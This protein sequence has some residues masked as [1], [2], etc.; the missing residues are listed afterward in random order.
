[1][2]VEHL[3]EFL[4]VLN[5]HTSKQLKS[6]Q[7]LP[8]HRNGVLEK[9]DDKNGLPSLARST[10]KRQLLR[11]VFFSAISHSNF[12]SIQEPPDCSISHIAPDCSVSRACV[13]SPLSSTVETRRFH[14]EPRCE[15]K[16]DVSPR[17]QILNG[18]ET[19]PS[20][21]RSDRPLEGDWK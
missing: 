12:Y 11:S 2:L 15:C 17:T 19:V 5:P 14:S 1:V 3:G 4:T 10:L 7:Y 21:L 18:Y 8:Q 6:N 13:A 16:R 20:L 9:F